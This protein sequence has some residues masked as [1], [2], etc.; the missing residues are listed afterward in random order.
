MKALHSVAFV[1]VIV[2]AL[3][4]LLEAIGWNL[5]EAILGSGSL[6]KIVYIVVGLS[7]VYLVLTHKKSCRNCEAPA[8]SAPQ[9]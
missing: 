7:A 8:S 2:G 4:W 9:M 5:V 1:L 3:N 6:A